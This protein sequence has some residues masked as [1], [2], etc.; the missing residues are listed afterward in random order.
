[1]SLVPG[2]AGD[3]KVGLVQII[4]IITEHSAHMHSRVGRDRFERN[5][6]GTAAVRAGDQL[7]VQLAAL[8]FSS[9]KTEL[10]FYPPTPNQ[11][12]SNDLHPLTDPHMWEYL[13]A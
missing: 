1:M 10:L 6:S 7:S 5:Y 3:S 11:F 2:D 12:C 9:S 13:E 8:L 4:L